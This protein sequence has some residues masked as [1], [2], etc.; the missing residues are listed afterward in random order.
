MV[1]VHQK[2][3]NLVM[4]GKAVFFHLVHSDGDDGRPGK[5]QKLRAGSLF[6]HGTFN[7]T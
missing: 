1:H 6:A 2:E 4:K 7:F 3:A 5:I